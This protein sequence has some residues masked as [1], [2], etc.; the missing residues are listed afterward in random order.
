[1]DSLQRAFLK[2]YVTFTQ[3]LQKVMVD[4]NFFSIYPQMKNVTPL[5]TV[6]EASK[7]KKTVHCLS[8]F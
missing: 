4:F 5:K 7:F 8:T 3:N 2:H 1:M 6:V